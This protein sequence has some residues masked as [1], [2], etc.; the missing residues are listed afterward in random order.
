MQRIIKTS[1][2]GVITS[3][4]ELLAALPRRLTLWLS[5]PP[6]RGKSAQATPAASAAAPIER[7][8][9]RAGE[10]IGSVYFDGE[11]LGGW[12]GEGKIR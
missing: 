8:R 5:A 1:R 7:P 3:T 12:P 4:I 10:P 9:R 6:A 2:P 11:R